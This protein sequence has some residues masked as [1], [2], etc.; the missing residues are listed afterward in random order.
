MAMLATSPE[1]LLPKKQRFRL[2][3]ILQPNFPTLPSLLL[4]WSGTFPHAPT[5]RQ[6][7]RMLRSFQCIIHQHERSSLFT[8]KKLLFFQRKK[9]LSAAVERNI[10][11]QSIPD[12]CPV[13]ML[14]RSSWV[15]NR[16]EIFFLT[17]NKREK[18]KFTRKANTKRKGIIISSW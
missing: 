17:H 4:N 8:L 11:P 9:I 1:I 5:H 2:R 13:R 6:R 7:L 16:A 15:A 10:S 14:R 18:N 12:H 3:V